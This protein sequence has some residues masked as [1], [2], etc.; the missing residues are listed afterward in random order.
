M[1][2]NYNVSLIS[3]LILLIP[4]LYFAINGKMHKKFKKHMINICVFGGSIVIIS[5]LINRFYI[6]N[7]E[8]K[9]F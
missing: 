6:N 3:I 2:Q 8:S 4:L 7:N 5:Y 1:E 9:I